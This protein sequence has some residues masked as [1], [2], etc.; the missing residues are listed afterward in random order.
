MEIGDR[1][2]LVQGHIRI[3]ENLAV[4]FG[5]QLLQTALQNRH[6]RWP[7]APCS[8]AMRPVK[9]QG[10]TSHFVCEADRE[11]M[12]FLFYV[13][14]NVLLFCVTWASLFALFGSAIAGTIWVL[15]R[16]LDALLTPPSVRKRRRKAAVVLNPHLL[17][18]AGQ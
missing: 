12:Q 5:A 13:V 14:F 10:S 18:R 3:P 16:F 4:A 6:A 11:A 8:A 2:H 15:G 1:R 7:P 9:S 17:K